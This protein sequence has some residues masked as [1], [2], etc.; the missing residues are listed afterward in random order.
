MDSVR[1]ARIS[2]LYNQAR[3]RAAPEARRFLEEACGAD[4][5]LRREVD[6]LLRFGRED[7]G[8]A[9]ALS[10]T[11]LA[12][13]RARLEAAAARGVAH[14]P[15]WMPAAIGGYRVLR[16]IG[17]GGMGV[18]YE[19]VQDSPRRH[20]ALKVLHP[21]LVSAE[22]V[23]RF[24]REA[25]VLGRLQHPG[26]AQVFEAG[27][28]DLGRG[29]QPWFAM[30]LVDGLDLRSWAARNE[31]DARAR[32]ALVAEV[33][34]AVQHAH[35][36]GIVHRDLK[37]DNVLVD[38]E[39]RAK[40]LDFGVARVAESSTMLSTLQTMQGQIV[41]TLV[42]MAPEQLEGDP[43][44]ISPRADV[45]ALGVI[46]F[47]LLV[48]R[49]PIEP[50]ELP[51]SAAVPLFLSSDATRLGALDPRLGGDVE[52]IVG[53]AL[54]KDP[55]RRYA[56]AADLAAD[57]R[58]HL[59]D[60]PIVAR[61][62]SVLYRAT[63]FTRRHRGLV[64]GTAATLFALLAGLV[65]AL[66]L[67]RS[68]RAQRKV[69]EERSTLARAKSVEAHAGVLRSARILAEERPLEAA[70]LLADSWTSERS[71]AWRHLETQL[72]WVLPVA[73][74]AERMGALQGV[75]TPEGELLF[76]RGEALQRL[77]L[78]APEDPQ[79]LFPEIPVGSALACSREHLVLMTR[80]ADLIVVRRDTGA[81]LRRLA[82]RAYGPK[83]FRLRWY[84][85]SP[86]EDEP[87]LAC[88]AAE[89]VALDGDRERYSIALPFVDFTGPHFGE[90]RLA[91]G[92]ERLLAIQQDG[93]GSDVTLRLFDTASGSELARREIP[94]TYRTAFHPDG[95]VL[96]VALAR[97]AMLLDGAT[98]G[99]TGRVLGQAVA[100]VAWAPDGAALATHESDGWIRLR[101]P[102]TGAVQRELEAG[103]PS[104]TSYLEFST[105]GRFLA[106]SSENQYMTL[107]ALESS[108][109]APPFLE[110]GGPTGWIYALALSPDGTLAAAVAP[111]DPHVF[112]WDLSAGTL[113]AR[114][115]RE[116]SGL[117][118]DMRAF[119]G[120]TP[121]G[122]ALVFAHAVGAADGVP[123]IRRWELASGAC[124][125]PA[126]APDD[127]GEHR[128]PEEV[129]AGERALARA[130]A[131]E[132]GWDGAGMFA[133][134]PD[135]VLLDGGDTVVQRDQH[136]RGVW[137]SR[138]SG[139]QEAFPDWLVTF[140]RPDPAHGRILGGASGN[141]LGL[142]PGASEP[143]FLFRRGM[144]PILSA[145]P[146]P[147]ERLLAI[148]TQ[149]G[150]IV[151]LEREFGTPVFEW[152][153]HPP[154]RAE[155]HYV[156]AL[157]WTPDGR[158]LITASGD[159]TLRV[160]DSV[161]PHVRRRWA[162][163][164]AARVADLRARGVLPDEPGLTREERAAA[165]VA[166]IESWF[167]RATR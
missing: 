58:R 110:L 31:L 71:W 112:L 56:S 33:A 146:S 94:S 145:E 129:S 99:D 23:R 37:P 76:P 126:L 123:P 28:A 150:R 111:E 69:A 159:G 14:D 6:D 124:S 132:L 43:Q 151:L 85:L 113:L 41:G 149:D 44:A 128:Y 7:P 74:E 142:T 118:T 19:G 92:G 152:Q 27:S 50:G 108:A 5:E 96:A 12:A 97:G 10:E 114:L 125:T 137:W 82:E 157:R 166:A 61:P 115:P 68:E 63:K 51:M 109:D 101:D 116:L 80:P 98:L 127:G 154:G 90:V 163:E 11:A 161:R 164:H 156:R 135:V 3:R 13:G 162:A 121:D 17:A 8:S 133:A 26:I 107:L 32:L 155:Y 57:L 18:V 16:R 53:K 103:T 119:L 79:P 64:G 95:S 4:A 139:A 72:P 106:A 30:E 55:A 117:V 75:F 131:R 136:D 1:H 100:G 42:Y 147:D 22:R 49:R 62:P 38:T 78:L 140:L 40:V 134:G 47:E 36:R 25:E 67:A 60:R 144:L 83:S 167:A 46:A 130:F 158:R 29:E 34:D 89:I 148:G 93:A 141:V 35:E 81:I 91:P 153:A 73:E 105:D 48:G 77:D 84:P 104:A 15:G 143:E 120:F 52:T 9:D 160:W 2:A 45:Y 70:R 59:A 66:V 87:F 54:E 39:G 21:A 86:A 24:R 122:R 165:L 65:T 138:R 20:V 88:T 102:A